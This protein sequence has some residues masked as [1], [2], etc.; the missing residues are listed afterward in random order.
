MI[1]IQTIHQPCVCKPAAP[2][3]APAPKFSAEL[4]R[5]LAQLVMLR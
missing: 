2:C 1:Q 4:M 5:M 3:P